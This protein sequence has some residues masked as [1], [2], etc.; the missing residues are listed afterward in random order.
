MRKFLALFLFLS[1][2]AYSQSATISGTITDGAGQTFNNGTYKIELVP[3]FGFNNTVRTDT[4]LP[5]TPTQFNGTLSSGG[6]FS[7]VVVTKT[8]FIGPAGAQWKFT[9]CPDATSGCFTY[10]TA[11]TADGD[12]STGLSAAAG[13]INVGVNFIKNII[14]TAY[15]SAEVSGMTRGSLY[16]NTTTN[17]LL[18]YD[19]AN[20]VDAVANGF[21]YAPSFGLV[22]GTADTTAG[23]QAGINAVSVTHGTLLVPP[24]AYTITSQLNVAGTGVFN[25]LC[26]GEGA[27][28][29]FNGSLVPTAFGSPDTTQRSR[30][31]MS[32]CKFN[33]T[34]AGQGTAI[35]ASH[36]A[37]SKFEDITM[38]GVNKCIVMNNVHAL[39][40]IVTRPNCFISGAG[41]VGL[42]FDSVAN[43]NTVF[44]ARI[45]PDAN[46]TC[47]S[48]NSQGVKLYDVDCE[49][50]ALI[51]LDIQ[52]S[53][54][55]TIAEGGWLEAN[56]TNLHIAAGAQ[57]PTILG[58]EIN[59]GTTA[60]F[61]DDGSTGL[62]LCG[63]RIQFI[64]QPCT[65]ASGTI[66][67]FY[68]TN[69]TNPALSGNFR[70]ANTD[71]F[72]FRNNAN[73]ADINALSPNSSDQLNVG[74]LA[75]IIAGPF[76]SNSSAAPA[77]VGI[78]RMVKTDTVK[79][80]NNAN[81]NNVTALSLAINDDIVVGSTNPVELPSGVSVGG[82]Q[83]QTALQGSTG[84]K[85]FSCTGSFTSGNYVKS[86]AN[87]NCVD[88]GNTVGLT[89]LDK[90]DIVAGINGNSA[91][92]TIYTYSMPANTLGSGKCLTIKSFQHRTAGA[93]S[94]TVKIFF[95]AT[96]VISS[97]SGSATPVS[98]TG[99][100]CNNA[101]ST[102]AQWAVG[103]YLSPSPTYTTLSTTP[104]ETT[105]SGSIVIKLTFN[106]AAGTSFGGDGWQVLLNP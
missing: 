75:G 62:N 1:S 84:T 48:V 104:A 68:Q 65:Q 91:D 95:G 27:I 89:T 42:K 16:Y 21:S 36:M 83:N 34:A 11:I 77:T 35:D 88:G 90:Q 28:I 20:W 50:G 9:V 24:G 3:A 44:K 97:T 85:L 43:E 45:H 105:T 51:G 32:G 6:A 64:S 101:G 78:V 37:I 8:N 76:I 38:T 39:Y 71:T 70:F 67:P 92:Q 93:G 81:T 17:S 86:D 59:S 52:A 55:G 7:G 13:T 18:A 79:F 33:S 15:N 47:V 61:T 4:G 87:G 80:R 60:N 30:I 66:G 26:T 29:N 72:K 23:F 106:V 14:P 56:Q 63:T 25:I 96:T 5:V 99:T 98:Q 82:S 100:V 10:S 12:L 31:S 54:R 22:S 53:A 40:N 69:S 46:A 73:S 2:F 74:G 19:G 41:S 102:T 94:A 57:T 103:E 58:M 49:T